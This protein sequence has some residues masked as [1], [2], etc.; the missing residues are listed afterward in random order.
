MKN[1]KMLAL[2]IMATLTTWGNSYSYA[3]AAPPAPT[4]PIDYQTSLAVAPTNTPIVNVINNGDVTLTGSNKITSANDQWAAN[5]HGIMVQNNGKVA[6]KETTDTT[7]VVKGNGSYGVY[8]TSGGTMMNNGE[9]N[10]VMDYTGWN[11]NTYAIAAQDKGEV[12][13]QPMV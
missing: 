13:L 9:L 4:E 2:A 5:S 3:L 12:I 1:K 10:I 6:V 11:G 7:I 8:A